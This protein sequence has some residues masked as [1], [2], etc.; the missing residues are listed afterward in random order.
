MYLLMTKKTGEL[1]YDSVQLVE[2][3]VTYDENLNVKEMQPLKYNLSGKPEVFELIQKLIDSSLVI[4]KEFGAPQDIEGGF[5]GNE[6]YLWQ[7]RNIV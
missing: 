1:T 2:P 3:Q 4:E 5:A 6:V 7:T